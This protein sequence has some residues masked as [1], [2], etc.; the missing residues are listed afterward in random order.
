MENLWAVCKD[1]LIKVD[2]IT[3]EKTICAV[4]RTWFHD[5]K[6]KETCEAFFYGTY[7]LFTLI[8]RTLP[9]EKPAYYVGCMC[10]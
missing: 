3:E 5:P 4:I 1:K 8:C 2:S 10:T 7:N 6:I 9:L